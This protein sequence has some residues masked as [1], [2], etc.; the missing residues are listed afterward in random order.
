[1]FFWYFVR[2][3]LPQPPARSTEEGRPDTV[4]EAWARSVQCVARGVR[5]KPF[6]S[7]GVDKTF[8]R[9]FSVRRLFLFFHSLVFQILVTVAHMYL[10]ENG[11]A[12][13][14]S[15]SLFR[16][17]FEVLY[18][19]SLGGLHAVCRASGVHMPRVMRCLVLFSRKKITGRLSE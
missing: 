18:N 17:R 10:V 7:V 19:S 3:L 5:P 12:C 14:N 13:H 15:G 9:V 4:V 11:T 2:A 8:S 6:F 16:D 1:M